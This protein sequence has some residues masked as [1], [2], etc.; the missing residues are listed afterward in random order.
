M[1]Q[2]ETAT[3]RIGRDFTFLQLIQFALPAILTNLCQ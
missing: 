1:Q 2:Q 3:N